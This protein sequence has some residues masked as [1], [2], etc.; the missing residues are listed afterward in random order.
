MFRV[1]NT[2][3]TNKF[4]ALFPAEAPAFTVLTVSS[5]A[6]AAAISPAPCGADTGRWTEEAEV[7]PA[8]VTEAAEGNA[9]A[10]VAPR[11]AAGGDG[12]TAPAAAS[13]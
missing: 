4:G 9:A 1:Q 12:G 13:T 7:A 5:C 10:Q 2:H 8:E 6:E 11:A 3:Y